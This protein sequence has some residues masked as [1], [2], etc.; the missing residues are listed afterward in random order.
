MSDWIATSDRM[1]PKG[2]VV[3]TKREDADGVH[4]HRPLSR[5]GASWFCHETKTGVYYTPTHWRPL[6]TKGGAA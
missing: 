5:R 6:P 2:V 1:P 4:D 3:D